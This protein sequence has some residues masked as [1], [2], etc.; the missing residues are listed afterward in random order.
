ARRA[1]R[2][3]AV[4]DAVHPRHRGPR[5]ASRSDRGVHPPRRQLRELH[6]LPMGGVRLRRGRDWRG[7]RARGGQRRRGAP[8]LDGHGAR[9]RDGRRRLRPVISADAVSEL[10]LRTTSP[11]FFFLRLGIMMAAFG[12]AWVWSEKLWGGQWQ[13]FVLLGQTSLFVYWVHV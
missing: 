8:R 2:R 6:T 4:R 10:S 9:R 12:L 11:A 1:G 7:A 3:A 13:P 5:G